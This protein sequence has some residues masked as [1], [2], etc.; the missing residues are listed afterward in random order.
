M[1]TRVGYSGNS[2]V[3]IFHVYTAGA[4]SGTAKIEVIRSFPFPLYTDAVVQKF[5]GLALYYSSSTPWFTYR[6]PS[7]GSTH[8]QM[9]YSDAR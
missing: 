7:N 5:L 6:R 4:E 3:L 2:Q 1:N 8:G 9:A